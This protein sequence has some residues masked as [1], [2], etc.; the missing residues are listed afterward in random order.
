[1]LVRRTWTN[2]HG[3]LLRRT[4]RFIPRPIGGRD[5]HRYCAIP[6]PPEVPGNVGG[7]NLLQG[8]FCTIG[9]HLVQLSAEGDRCLLHWR[10]QGGRQSG[11]APRSWFKGGLPPPLDGEERYKLRKV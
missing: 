6:L 4:R 1:M 7:V 9:Y 2:V 8:G 3:Q 11:H 10:L 5:H